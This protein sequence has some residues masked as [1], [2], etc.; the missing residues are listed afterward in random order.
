MFVFQALML[1][2]RNLP[3]TPKSMTE[4]QLQAAQNYSAIEPDNEDAMDDEPTGDDEKTEYEYSED[5]DDSAS[6]DNQQ[7]FILAPT[8]AQL[9]RAPL[10][11]R[12]GSLVGGD[13]NSMYFMLWSNFPI[14]RKVNILLKTSS[15]FSD[16]P[17]IVSNEATLPNTQ[18][19]I[20]MSESV[21]SALPTPNSAAM[22]DVHLQNQLSPTMQKKI[23]FKKVKGEDLN[24]YVVFMD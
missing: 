10:Q 7:R 8:P 23:M 20:P 24:K 2:N 5:Y 14:D 6:V 1:S 17:Q 3:A 18:P 21:P 15:Y 22:E 11:R 4:S 16:Q 9:G 19:I 13:A 12:L